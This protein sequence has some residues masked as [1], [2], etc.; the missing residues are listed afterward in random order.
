MIKVRTGVLRRI[1]NACESAML[2]DFVSDLSREIVD[3]T[4][5]RR[6]RLSP[7]PREGGPG[8]RPTGRD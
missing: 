8:D 5:L 1:R 4:D 7:D 6:G 2:E 3:L